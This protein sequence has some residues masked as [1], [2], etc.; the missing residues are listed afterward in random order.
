MDREVV[1]SNPGTDKV[2]VTS[3]NFL[4]VYLFLDYPHTHANFHISHPSNTTCLVVQ[5]SDY[6]LPFIL[7]LESLSKLQSRG[8]VGAYHP[9]A[10]GSNLS[11]DFSLITA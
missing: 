8:S 6:L 2:F 4:H 7:H 11:S 9:A 5:S 3:I 10:P 1:G